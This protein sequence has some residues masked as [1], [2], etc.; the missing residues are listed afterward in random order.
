M[1]T[2]CEECGAVLSAGTS[3]REYF[4]RLL[5]LEWELPGGPGQDTHFRAVSCYL[6]QHPGSMDCLP[7]ALAELE[8]SLIEHWRHQ[9]PI[10]QIRRRIRQA[11]SGAVLA[12][13][14]V[15]GQR[16][17]PPTIRWTVSIADVLFGGTAEYPTR[18]DRWVNSVVTTLEGRA[19]AGHAARGRRGREE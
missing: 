3:C 14:G 15:I 6:L 12:H 1:R 13:T 2:T 17:F 4:E 18:V 11:V 10:T 19:P 7:G 16:R 5:A 8:R 9:R